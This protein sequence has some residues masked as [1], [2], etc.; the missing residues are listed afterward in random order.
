[1]RMSCR[2]FFMGLLLSTTS[3][4]ADT[5]GMAAPN[6]ALADP[7]STEAIERAM[8]DQANQA[9][10]AHNFTDFFEVLAMSPRL[11]RIFTAAQVR[12]TENGKTTS[13]PRARYH[14][15]PV[16]S[17][18]WNYIVAGS[19]KPGA[20]PDYVELRID[21][22]SG[23]AVRVDWVRARYDGDHGGGD[24]LGNLLELIGPPGRLIFE[25]AGEGCWHL[26]QDIRGPRD[27]RFAI[28]PQR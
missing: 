19:F 22:T 2:A 1:M 13:V 15:F 26:T 23:N 27:S 20:E 25:P 17:L 6:A 8:L 28:G 24:G 10:K 14:R 4:C 9:C 16:E 18:D 3:S 11:R 21:E 12:V 5:R 7:E